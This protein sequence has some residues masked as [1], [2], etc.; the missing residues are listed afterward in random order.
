MKTK[1]KLKKRI[2]SNLNDNFMSHLVGGKQEQNV[3]G[4]CSAACATK[5]GGLTDGGFCNPCSSTCPC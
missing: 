2:I 5:T 4:T 3:T 1:L